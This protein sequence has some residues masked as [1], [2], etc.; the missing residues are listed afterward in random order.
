MNVGIYDPYLDDVGGGEKYMLTIA[1]VL[2][3]EHNVSVFWNNK[4]DLEKAKN[5]FSLDLSRVHVV[6]NIFTKQTPFLKRLAASKKYDAII[7]LSDGSIPIVRS[8]LYIHVQRPLEHVH[9]SL[10]ARLKIMRVTSFFCNS[11]F[12]KRYIDKTF[13]IHSNVIYPPVAL[14]PKNETKTNT[15]LHVGRFR[16]FDK[17]VDGFSDFKKQ[18]VMLQVFK[19][20]VDAGLKNWKF[21]MAVSV[22][23]ADMD[24]FKEMREQAKGY[25]VEFEVN[26]SNASL[27]E[28]YS[29]AKIYWH[30]SGFGENLEKHP[31][32]AEHFGISTVEA[33]GAG[34]V[35][36]VIDAGGQKEIV[37]DGEN[38]FTWSTLDELKEKTMTLIDS[39]NLLEKL[40]AAARARAQDFT[41]E[42][43]ERKIREMIG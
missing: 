19:E 17:T 39:K 36:V 9:P 42:M 33:M 5:R 16:V 25:P 7:V 28:Y 31:E 3:R 12:T 10:I 4:E 20:V 29:K 21:I 26:K 41:K 13:K 11:Q 30:A 37:K 38:G 43:F 8:K 2:S 35:P 40:S 18:H 6:H 15:I 27:W 32:F 1:E 22:Q 14:D 24:A 23:D 34:A